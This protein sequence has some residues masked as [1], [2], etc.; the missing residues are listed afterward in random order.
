MAKNTSLFTMDFFMNFKEGVL[1]Y[2]QFY[3]HCSGSN[4][5]AISEVCGWVV[6]QTNRKLV[7]SWWNLPEEDEVTRKANY[8]LMTIEK[9]T[10]IRK[11]K[12]STKKRG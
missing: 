5:L 4:D 6:G 2:V 7:L 3:D 8:E 11:K 12:L 10:I 9:G 1:Y